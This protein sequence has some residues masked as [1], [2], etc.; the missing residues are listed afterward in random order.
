M[1]F[2][3]M[4]AQK[5]T[6]FQSWHLRPLGHS[7]SFLL[8]NNYIKTHLVELVYT[9]DLKSVPLLVMGSSPIVGINVN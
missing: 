2:E 6:N 8:I 3:L 1:R 4:Y 5:H 7:S 9:A